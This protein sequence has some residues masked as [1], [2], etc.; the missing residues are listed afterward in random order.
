MGNHIRKKRKKAVGVDAD[1]L[2][3]APYAE[4]ASQSNG[5]GKTKC[6]GHCSQKRQKK[7]KVRNGQKS[8]KRLILGPMGRRFSFELKLPCLS[9]LLRR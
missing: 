6:T 7:I 8:K 9:C 4:A 5:S 3:R 2:R 1:H